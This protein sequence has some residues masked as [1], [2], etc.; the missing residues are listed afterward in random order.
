MVKKYK[1][2]SIKFN[3]TFDIYD[4]VDCYNYMNL[5]DYLKLCKH[6]YSKVTD[7]A[8]REV[9]FG[10]LSRKEGL[11]LIK[12]YELKKPD[13]IQEFCDWIG[14][15]EQSLNFIIDQQRNPRYWLKTQPG[16]WDFKGL[17]SLIK[18]NKTEKSPKKIHYNVNST[19]EYD[20][21]PLYVTVGKGYP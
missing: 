3:R 1:Y 15:S 14:I 10:R 2:K 13:Y 20:H 7:H 16:K 6:G 11:N 21:K 19:L 12:K 18:L 9:R 17:S 5:H 4:Y 8:T